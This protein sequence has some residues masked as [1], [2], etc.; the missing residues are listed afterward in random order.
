VTVAVNPSGIAHG[1]AK[2]RKAALS[3]VRPN[4]G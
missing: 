2:R 4:A 1:Y 3:P